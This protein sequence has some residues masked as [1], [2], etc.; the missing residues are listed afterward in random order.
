MIHKKLSCPKFLGLGFLSIAA[1][2]A[3]EF[4]Q[5]MQTFYGIPGQT[6]KFVS[7]ILYGIVILGWGSAFK[8]KLQPGSINLTVTYMILTSAAT[9]ILKALLAFIPESV[10]GR[11][12][13]E[14]LAVLPA[15]IFPCLTWVFMENVKKEEKA[16]LT[17]GQKIVLL[18]P[19]IAGLF[20]LTEPIHNLIK[21]LDGIP[22]LTIA[23]ALTFYIFGFAS[24]EKLLTLKKHEIHSKYKGISFVLFI[25]TLLVPAWNSLAMAF[26]LP[27]LGETVLFAM[28]ISFLMLY[29]LTVTDLLPLQKRDRVLLPHMQIP[30]L[31]YDGDIELVGK[32]KSAPEISDPLFN[33]LAEKGKAVY[34][35]WEISFTGIEN[36]Y[37]VEPIIIKTENRLKKEWSDLCKEATTLKETENDAFKKHAFDAVK[38]KET[39]ENMVLLKKVGNAAGHQLDSIERITAAFFTKS[40]DEQRMALHTLDLLG[41]FISCTAKLY[42]YDGEFTSDTLLN[43]IEKSFKGLLPL[44][45]QCETDIQKGVN[46]SKEDVLICY[47]VFEEI[48]EQTLSSLKSIKVS[49]RDYPEVR[50]FS[51]NAETADT[52]APAPFSNQLTKLL[53]KHCD[54]IGFVNEPIEPGTHGINFVLTYNKE[55]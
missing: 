17:K 29:S 36:G 53:S 32:S 39:D 19:I 4:M 40:E 33:Y 41:T 34:G 24:F 8:R 48:L 22:V 23:C 11:S 20:I 46:L 49:L 37:L 18:W 26:D 14:S 35:D 12:V 25:I 27:L 55:V 51:V 47:S 38:T 21:K 5:S 28:G 44:K 13:I 52:F 7:Y 42:T 3:A 15:F 31:L 54:R 10:T 2:L 30:F 45:T 9:L 1:L 43:F 50:T 16:K 6:I